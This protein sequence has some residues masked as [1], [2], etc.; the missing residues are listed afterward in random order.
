[1]TSSWIPIYTAGGISPTW[2]YFLVA[3]NGVSRVRYQIPSIV[4][5]RNTA[6]WLRN[7]VSIRDGKGR[8]LVWG[9]NHSLS[10]ISWFTCWTPT[11]LPL[12]ANLEVGYGA[13]QDN[14]TRRSKFND[15][16]LYCWSNNHF[17]TFKYLYISLLIVT[18]C[19]TFRASD[20]FLKVSW[21]L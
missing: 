15:I 1:V 10:V 7:S 21:F 6:S 3:G 18:L 20:S 16:P 12:T 9:S 8:V 2:T 11:C 5:P 13:K 14:K 19:P 17:L 4:F